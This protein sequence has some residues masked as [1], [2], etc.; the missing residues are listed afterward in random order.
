MLESN[1]KCDSLA[2]WSGLVM[3]LR[4]FCRR[5]MPLWKGSWELRCSFVHVKT[6][7]SPLPDVICTGNLFLD[8]SGTSTV[9]ARFLLLRRHP[10]H[11][12]L[13]QRQWTNIISVLEPSSTRKDVLILSCLWLGRKEFHP[14]IKK[15]LKKHPLP[16]CLGFQKLA[17]CFFPWLLLESR[18]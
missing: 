7:I 6:G 17:S 4:L 3:R 11:N 8:V 10:V 2:L 13:L 14:V 5:L 12:V 1:S 15:T 16:H 18:D 9:R